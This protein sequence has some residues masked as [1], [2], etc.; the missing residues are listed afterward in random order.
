MDS[1]Y[2]K[3]KIKIMTDRTRH[4][5]DFLDAQNKD[6]KYQETKKVKEQV[7][8]L[9]KKHNRKLLIDIINKESEDK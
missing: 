7:K 4:N 3:K 1:E 9:L 5:I 8:E 6:R 2:R